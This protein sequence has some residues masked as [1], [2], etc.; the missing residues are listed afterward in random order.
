MKLIPQ[1][2]LWEMINSLRCCLRTSGTSPTEQ[3]CDS[4]PERK[5]EVGKKPPPLLQKTILY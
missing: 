5:A 1:T 3:R 2:E 4:A